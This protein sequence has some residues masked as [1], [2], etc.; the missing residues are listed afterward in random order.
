MVFIQNKK[1]NSGMFAVL[2]IYQYITLEQSMEN[3]DI[4]LFKNCNLD[5]QFTSNRKNLLEYAIL[6]YNYNIVKI[7]IE[8]NCNIINNQ[9]FVYS[10]ISILN[11]TN[12]NEYLN[13]FNIFKLLLSN[14]ILKPI[15]KTKIIIKNGLEVILK[16]KKYYRNIIFY[17]LNY[18]PNILDYTT[19]YYNSIT[20]NL[21]NLYLIQ[22][23]LLTQ[24]F[25][26]N[27]FKLYNNDIKYIVT[28]FLLIVNR[29]NI[30]PPEICDLILDN[31]ELDK[32][33]LKSLRRY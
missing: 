26:R 27:S 24:K 10:I 19:I 14:L 9:A 25:K 4:N 6:Y 11:S 3:I 33:K 1:F 21:N 23:P 18:Y 16:E 30:L 28:L 13:S 7:L 17:I 20:V 32:L 8:Y 29:N 15:D 12:K 22:N 31:L 5:T 2:K